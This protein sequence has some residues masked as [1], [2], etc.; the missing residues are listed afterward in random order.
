MV[1]TF[2]EAS[3]QMLTKMRA[4]NEPL[5]AGTFRAVESR[6]RAI[7]SVLGAMPLGEI[8]GKH[9]E[10]YIAAR[11]AEDLS[12]S[13]INGEYAVI[14]Q[15]F[16]SVKD[17][18][19][20]CIY[21]IRWD[22]KSIGLPG[23]KPDPKRTADTDLRE[24]ERAV[25]ANLRPFSPLVACLG[26]TGLRLGEAVACRVSADNPNVTH[27]DRAQSLIRVRTAIDVYEDGDE[28]Y[29]EHA[30]KTEKGADRIVDLCAE[31]NDFLKAYAGDRRE[32]FLFTEDGGPLDRNRLYRAASKLCGPF[33][34]LRRARITYLYDCDPT[35]KEEQIMTFW[36]G[37]E[38]KISQTREY[39]RI[40]KNVE[41]RRQF[42]TRA[43]VGF[44]LAAHR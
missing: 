25:G 42:A 19:K 41:A 44:R 9:I 12:G 22:E 35:P 29:G 31:A 36:C 1:L 14:R 23:R 40:T 39:S 43:G 30:A 24:I 33:H 7:N 5:K 16:K 27:W 6:L 28:T 15:V 11:V 10:A 21:P 3:Q 38:T 37:H 8:K 2:A 32:G 18:D 13:T 20:N 17:D 26:F 34:G 4:E